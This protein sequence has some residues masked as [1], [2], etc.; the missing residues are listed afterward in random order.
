M[1][2][3]LDREL[4]IPRDEFDVIQLSL[5]LYPDYLLLID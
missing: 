4:D 3:E 2:T 5:E 1:T